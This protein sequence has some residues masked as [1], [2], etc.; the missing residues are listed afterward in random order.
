[1]IKRIFRS[2]L[3]AQFFYSRRLR[4]IIRELEAQNNIRY[5][6]LKIYNV[7]MNFMLIGLVFICP[8]VFVSDGVFGTIFTFLFIA[9][10]IFWLKYYQDNS[11]LAFAKGQRIKAEIVKMQYQSMSKDTHLWC[12]RK[13]TGNVVKMVPLFTN[14]YEH[15]GVGMHKKVS[16]F[17][18]PANKKFYILDI[19]SVRHANCIRKD[20]IQENPDNNLY[21]KQTT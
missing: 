19:P 6:P 5:E 17:Q 9:G 15:E 16:I 10:M 11:L 12:K 13:D 21:F 14:R 3:I 2:G 4:V 1:M 8:I 7:F 18:S 20:F